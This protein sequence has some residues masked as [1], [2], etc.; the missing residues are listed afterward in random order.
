MAEEKL[1]LKAGVVTPFLSNFAM[2][3]DGENFLYT[4]LD[5]SGKNI[6][7]LNKFIEEA[8][9]VYYCIMSSNNIPDPTSLKELQNL[10]TL[11]LG[12]NKIKNITIFT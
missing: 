11:D 10:I 7:A 4:T 9:D 12:K 5:M 3:T 1:V 2:S 8:K 6:E